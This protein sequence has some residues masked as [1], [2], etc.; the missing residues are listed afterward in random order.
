[1]E[2]EAE[3]KIIEETAEIRF[4]L[5][6][7]NDIFSDFDP[8]PMSERGLSEDFLSEAKRACMDKYSEKINFVILVPD[9]I[10]KPKDEEII[11]ERLKKHF[12][13]HHSLLKK[14]K[15]SVLKKG[16]GF[17][18]TGVIIMVI[19]TI[20]LFEFKEKNIITSFFTILLEPA[21]WFLFWEGMHLVIFETKKTNPTLKFNEKMANA[22]INFT[23]V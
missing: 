7:Y 13:K 16:I 11:K 5:D 18:V 20:L 12:K 9:K 6:D 15:N 1:M 8:R 23:S 22:S 14:K 17:W 10:R 21:G 2:E 19:A 4:T 3:E